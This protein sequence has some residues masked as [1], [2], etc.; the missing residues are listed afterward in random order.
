VSLADEIERLRKGI[1]DYRAGNY[2]SPRSHRPRQCP[3]GLSYWQECDACNDAALAAI[4]APPAHGAHRGTT[5][6][7]EQRVEMEA[8]AIAAYR[9]GSA[10]PTG[11]RLPNDIWRQA[12]PDAER[13]IQIS[14][15]TDEAE[16][17]WL[18]R[19]ATG[20]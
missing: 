5:M 3:H 14:D 1:E 15:E 7:Y 19:Q 18:E 8:R 16:H 12:I 17:F 6:T 13:S 20:R 11:S 10:D 2:E 9:I 4:L